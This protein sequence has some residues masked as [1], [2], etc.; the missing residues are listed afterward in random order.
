MAAV[1]RAAV[2][3][4]F[5]I[6]AQPAPAAIKIFTKQSGA[7]VVY[8][9]EDLNAVTTQPVKG[10]FIPADA[11]AILFEGSG[12]SIAA[13]GNGN[14]A[15]SRPSVR[16]GTVEGFVRSAESGRPVAGASVA[17][18]ETGQ[19][20]VTDRRGRFTLGDV[21]PGEHELRVTA[22]GMQ[23][24]RV[25]DVTVRGGHRLTLSPIGIPQ[26]KEGVTQ[27]EE[28]VVSAKKNDGVVELDPYDVES[29]REKP[30]VANVD[31]PR[32][33]NDPQPY[34]IFEAKTIDQSGAL[35]VE[36]F[37]KTRLT[38]NTAAQSSA[39]NPGALTSPNT[40]GNTSNINLRGLGTDSTL[41]LI[42]GRRVAGVGTNGLSLQQPDLNGIPL[43]AIERIEVLPSSASGIYG[44][45]AIGGVV[46]VILKKNYT[47]GE[48][49]ASYDNTWD[50]D[51]P[52]RSAGLSYGAALEDGKTYLNLS[53]AWSDSKDLLLQ[54]R[55]ELIDRGVA[56]IFTNSPSF[57]YSNTNPFLGALPN[58]TAGT[59]A[60]T[61]LTLKS[62][63]VIASR[64]TFIPAGTSP[65][66]S[67]S[68]L[69]AGLI[70]NAGLWNFDLPAST[71]PNTGL[72]R[73]LGVS[74]QTKSFTGGVRRQF[75]PRVE[76][77]ADYTYNEN[78]S[79]SVYNPNNSFLIVPATSP[80]NPFTSAVRV[81]ITDPAQ[82]PLTTESTSKSLTI[83]AIARLPWNWNA[84]FDY[85][86]SESKFSSINYLT[87][88]GALSA[89]LASGILNPFVD[90]LMF[91][92]ALEK[93]TVPNVY[94]GSSK[95]DDFAIRGSGPLPSLPWGIPNLTLGL[96]HRI[97]STPENHL[98]RPYPISKTLS[99]RYVFFDREDVTNSA[100]GEVT[101]P[102][103]KSGHIPMVHAL[104][105]QTAG[106][107]EHY[108]AD[109]GSSYSLT[110]FDR[111]PVQIIYGAPTLNGLPYRTRTRYV[112]TNATVGLK[113][114]PVADVT[115][116]SSYAT[117]FLPPYPS[118]LVRNPLPDLFPSTVIDPRTGAMVDVETISGGNPDLKPQNSKSWNVGLIWEPA[119]ALK[120]LRV[121]AEYY[122]IEQFDAV[123]YLSAQ[124]IVDQEEAFPGRVTR[125]GSGTITGVDITNVNVYRLETEGW[126]FS[127]HYRR[128]TSWGTFTAQLT[129]SVL[130]HLKTQYSLTEPE[131]D[132][133]GYPADGG[134]A[135]L[136]S[137]GILFWER[138]NW[139]AGWSVQHYGKYR[140]YGAAGG[141]LSMQ[142]TGGAVF[143]TVVAA[144]GSETIPSQTYHD[145]F[146][147]YA[148]GKKATNDGQ[149]ARPASILAGMT[150][151][152][153]VRNVFGKLPPYDAGYSFYTSPYGDIRLRSYSLSVRKSF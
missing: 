1:T 9:H 47:G 132:G 49:R 129:G 107:T 123:G 77:F 7:Q 97:A 111:T 36:D 103:V 106:R 145:I 55:R 28:F 11:L 151:Q 68:E 85:T 108:T 73:P 152:V 126:D 100:Y 99:Y 117:A 128:P 105:L 116:R 88:G 26:R 72:L 89:D 61:T 13:T 66:T 136:K 33:I 81:R 24:T 79:A 35:N 25:V 113:Y 70:S 17:V 52:R 90:T 44:G 110:Y 149:W 109:T 94:T 19:S 43:G 67:S 134:A 153:G 142:Y 18:A 32:T 125:D 84:E 65:S 6:P 51:A 53:V 46:N 14:F 120:G 131:Y 91:P 34:Y 2:P 115:I 135:K 92:L 20:V 122:R 21:P 121:N 64:R 133:A 4:D 114:Q 22:D 101:L 112:S 118:Q 8:L 60:A 50:T 130:L 59:T 83:G 124:Q 140:Q 139:A 71:Q 41:I 95:L 38:M 3:V 29:R 104:E 69:E 138:G 15:L 148:F 31:I 16:A 143:S 150:I 40:S 141:P 45:S 48:I 102:L 5:D 37:L 87:D 62:G 86:R 96:G 147:S 80:V 30:F 57:L 56:S 93:Y 137:N 58:I 78:R 27:L 74:P 12:L 39:Q 98:D 76:L 54:D 63:A 146:A 144:Q 75:G 119:V 82:F 23:S 127:V 10:E 42:N